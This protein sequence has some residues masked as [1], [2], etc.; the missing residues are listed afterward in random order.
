MD[1]RNIQAPRQFQPNP[2]PSNQMPANQRQPEQKFTPQPGIQPVPSPT[3][4]IRVSNPRYLETTSNITKQ[5]NRVA[6]NNENFGFLNQEKNLRKDFTP[7][8]FVGQK[9]KVI[10]WF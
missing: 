9:R 2:L 4:P 3:Q 6:L 10:S 5:Q 7:K 8:Q 1:S